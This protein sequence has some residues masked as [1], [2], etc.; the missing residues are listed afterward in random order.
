MDAP[1]SS[2][3]RKIYQSIATVVLSSCSAKII[4]SDQSTGPFGVPGG[5]EEARYQAKVCGNHNS[6]QVRPIGDSWDQSQPLWC[7][8]KLFSQLGSV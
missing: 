7:A 3:V 1:G 5:P 6:S 2:D 8:Q 4:I